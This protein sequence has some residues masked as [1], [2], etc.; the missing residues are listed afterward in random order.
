MNP[1]YRGLVYRTQ[2]KNKKRMIRTW[3]GS[4]NKDSDSNERRA[5]SPIFLCVRRETEIKAELI[6]FPRLWRSIDVRDAF[7]KM[8]HNG[9]LIVLCSLA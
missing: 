1:I 9:T 2:N 8:D 5:M 7:R 6:V 4:A 3:R